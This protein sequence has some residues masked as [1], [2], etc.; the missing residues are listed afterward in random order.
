[1]QLFQCCWYL[2]QMII[3]SEKRRWYLPLPFIRKADIKK[4]EATGNFSWTGSS[5]FKITAKFLSALSAM[6]WHPIEF[7][8]FQ[9]WIWPGS[10]HT[11][12]M[13]KTELPPFLRLPQYR[14]LMKLTAG[15]CRTWKRKYCFRERCHCNPWNS[16]L[17]EALAD[18]CFFKDS[19]TTN[20]T[21][22]NKSS[23]R[24]ARPSRGQG[25]IAFQTWHWVT[26]RV[27]W[28]VVFP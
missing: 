20:A 6:S 5:F 15:K 4:P 24:K 11:K 23:E 16:G 19:S 22:S 7:T 18:R 3:I 21:V 12:A 2:R 17:R 25:G 14:T 10:L 8:G 1:M 26:R 13:E 27:I 9:G 28:E